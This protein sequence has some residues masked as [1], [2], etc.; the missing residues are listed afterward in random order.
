[1]QKLIKG[2]HLT[3]LRTSL[4]I[5]IVVMALYACDSTVRTTPLPVGETI[6][7]VQGAGHISPFNNRPV[8]NVYG[9]VT[10]IRGDGFYMQSPSPDDDLATSEG[11]FVY[12]GMVP[13]VKPGDLVSVNAMV[14]E[15]VPGGEETGNLSTTQLIN[16]YITVLSSGNEVPAPTVIGES[17][18]M[19][20]TEIIDNDSNGS[21]ANT[22]SFDPD[23]DGLDFYESLEGMRLQVN[24]AIVV[25]ATSQFKEIV[26][27]P[28]RG[29]WASGMTARGGLILKPGD[30]NPERIVL[31]DSL[32]QL[33]FVQVG[34]YSDQPIIGVL[35]YTFGNFKLQATEKVQF[36]SA[37]LLPSE[38]LVAAEEGQLRV[39][40]YNVLN[41]SA[42]DTEKIARLAD[43]IV[44]LM[45][46]PDIIG[47]QEIQDNDGSI[48]SAVISA[49]ET[50][51]EIIDAVLQLGGPEYQFVDIDPSPNRDGG[52]PGG[53]IRVGFLYR[54]DRGLSLIQAPHGDAESRTELVMEKGKPVLSLNPGRI[55]PSDP[56][57]FDSRKPLVAT[58]AYQGDTIFVVNNHFNSKGGDSPLFGELQ[59]PVL[60]SETQ[61]IQQAQVVHGFVAELLNIDPQAQ[62]IVMGD[63]NDFY[64]SAPIERLKGDILNNL[65]ETLPV[66]ARYTY[67]YD[68][69]SQTLDHILVS[70]ALFKRRLSMDVLHI[71]SEFDYKQRFGDHDILIATFD[72]K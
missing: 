44:S 70:D 42:R 25:G 69:N 52:I 41:L 68:G 13:G 15:F 48:N 49:D 2:R 55:E 67:V 7:Q 59:P 51:Q 35:D 1:M 34:D 46:S 3:G 60:S 28:D 20:P 54:M 23:E 45:A 21:A 5:L 32:R 37:G 26:V 64:F 43:Q 10:A 17:G 72:L 53:N 31:D 63:L 29:K 40:C 33:P 18:R 16:P 8:Y 61:R 38:G 14:E 12:K 66:E 24:Q 6:A 22:L 9:I 56:A 36:T 62:V 47:L 50:Y 58:F 11:I 19:P 57:F 30:F 4:L 39:A 71:N 65:I 27:V